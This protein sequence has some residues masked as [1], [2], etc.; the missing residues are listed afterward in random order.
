MD[1]HYE[2]IYFEV[3]KQIQQSSARFSVLKIN[4]HIVTSM[5]SILQERCI[6]GRIFPFKFDRK[7]VKCVFRVH[8]EI[9]LYFGL[10]GHIICPNLR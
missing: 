4:P 1:I 8:R 9:I 7:F 5:G 3:G 10:E 6:V 2:T